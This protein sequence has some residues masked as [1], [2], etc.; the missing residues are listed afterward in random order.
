MIY[1]W[2]PL[3]V[4]LLLLLLI[5]RFYEKFS[6][7]RTYFRWYVVPVILFGA[8]MARYASVGQLAGDRLG[9]VISALAGVVL[10]LL[11]VSL[12]RLMAAG[13]QS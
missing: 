5:A 6:G 1:T 13:R 2:F 7:K 8:A 4:L 9:D 12:Y 10:L 3:A 11:T